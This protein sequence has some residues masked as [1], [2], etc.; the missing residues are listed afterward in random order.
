MIDL[1]KIEGTDIAMF[2][3][4]DDEYCPYER[5]V[6]TKEI[7]GDEVTYFQKMQGWD[8]ARFSYDSSVDFMQKLTA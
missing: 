8:H 5:A 2:V 1:S 3:A 6:E 7:I 4:T